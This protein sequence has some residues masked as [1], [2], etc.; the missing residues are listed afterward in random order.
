MVVLSED[1][2]NIPICD[3][4]ILIS[5][6]L[7]DFIGEFIDFNKKIFVADNVLLELERKFN[8]NTEY[9]YLL[10][11]VKNNEN[12]NVINKDEYFTEDRILV[13]NAS[14]NQYKLIEDCLLTGD[15]CP[16]SGEFISAIYA[17]NLE[18]RKFITNDLKFINKYK[19]EFIFKG[20][21]FINMTQVLDKIIGKEKRKGVVLDINRKSKEMED[22]LTK[23]K[24]LEKFE[25][26]S[27]KLSCI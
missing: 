9:S 25:K 16:D 14:L 18:I 11:N 15:L 4:N 2:K 20:L 27:L 10:Q 17:A 7:S 21:S 26:W 13:M 19:D 1:E 12:I 6:G 3:T 22:T 23:E 5:F 8:R 24:V